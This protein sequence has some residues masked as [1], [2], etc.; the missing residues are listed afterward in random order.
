[1][2]ASSERV[3]VYC[4]ADAG[5]VFPSLIALASMRRFHPEHSYFIIADRARLRSG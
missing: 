4:T 5:Y 2:L 1:M 3:A